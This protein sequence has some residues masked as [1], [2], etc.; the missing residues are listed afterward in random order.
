MLNLIW[1][2][3]VEEDSTTGELHNNEMTDEARA[4][5][6]TAVSQRGTLDVIDGGSEYP[7][8]C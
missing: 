1:F 6:E 3:W 5:L 8:V 4:L 2:V 7:V